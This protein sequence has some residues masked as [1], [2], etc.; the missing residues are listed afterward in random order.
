MSRAKAT[1][2][3]YNDRVY[4]SARA[5]MLAANPVCHEPGCGRPARVADHWPPLSQ[6]D[7]VTGGGCSCTLLPHCWRHSNG[8]GGRLRSRYG[9]PEPPP[10]VADLVAAVEREP[11]GFPVDDPAWD[12]APW[13][14][15]LRE[16][17]EEGSW[18]R[19]MTPPHPRAVDSLGEEFVSFADDRMGGRLRWWQRLAAARLLEVDE[20]GRLVW[21]AALV[22]TA[23]QVG[24]STLLRELAIWRLLQADRY[25]EPQLIVHVATNRA[26][27]AEI[28]RG[29][30]AWARE[31][32]AEFPRTMSANGYETVEHASGSRWLIKSRAGTYGHSSSLAIVDEGWGI[33]ASEVEDGLIPT[34]AETVA[35]QLL[36]TSTANRKATSL[37]LGRRRAALELLDDPG[38][39]DLLL[40]WSAPHGCDIADPAMW[41]MASPHWTEQRQKL[42]RAAVERALA[43]DHDDDGEDPQAAVRGQWL[44][45]WQEPQRKLDDRGEPLL[46]EGVWDE[47]RTGEH[48]HG[49]RW[50]VAIEDW[51]GQGGAVAACG[52]L[53]SGGWLL[54]GWEHQSRAEAV[55][56]VA[57]LIESFPRVDLVAGATLHADPDVAELPLSD[58]P[59]TA[60]LTRPALHLFREM[61]ADRR[62]W[63][64]PADGLELAAAVE[65]ARVVERQ[66]GLTLIGERSDLVKAAV[67]ALLTQATPKPVPA[68][69]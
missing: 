7:H 50:T 37:V 20:D 63:W 19:L 59:G 28:Q 39:G 69:Y 17:P 52:D 29:A 21:S 34:L 25:G 65:R 60:A 56:R 9:K 41:R 44:N 61:V 62:V 11:E 57:G 32:P 68:V 13:L 33:P 1:N 4:R 16:V 27:A 18:P 31:R 48:C 26:I 23:R 53:P 35:P 8:Q 14:D 6:H 47:L 15:E 54:A 42:I 49:N 51:Y 3:A 43:G 64:D 5:A 66:T 67:W 22:L 24:K 2:R 40:E 38:A 55:D 46:P 30:R 36:I 12:F 10:A 45:R 58:T